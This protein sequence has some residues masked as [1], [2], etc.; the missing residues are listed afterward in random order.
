MPKWLRDSRTAL[1]ETGKALIAYDEWG[2]NPARAAGG[3][4]FNV[5]TTV[6]T[7]G[8][9]TAAK[10]GAVAR[11]VSALGKAGRAVDPMTYV[12]KA[13]GF[14]TVKVLDLFKTLK[15]LPAAPFTDGA[16]LTGPHIE[17]SDGSRLTYADGE[18]TVTHPDGT[19]APAPLELSAADR[20]LLDNHLPHQEPAMAGGQPGEHTAGHD[21]GPGAGSPSTSGDHMS[22]ERAENWGRG[23]T[24]SHGGADRA[25]PPTGPRSTPVHDSG[26][27]GRPADGREGVAH[28]DDHRSGSS[29]DE[30]RGH[31]PAEPSGDGSHPGHE[32]EADSVRADHPAEPLSEGPDYT[33]SALPPGQAHLSLDQLRR[34]RDKR[35]RW[36]A[37]EDYFRQMH[38]GGAERH[39][40]VPTNSH[41]LYPVETT[42]GRKVD[43]PV[44]LPD[45]RTLA[46]EVKTYQEYRTLTLDGGGHQTVK[47]E[48]P[49][50][51]H[52]REQI[53]KDLALRRA[54]PTFDPRWVFTHAGPSAE[55][56]KYLTEARI[57][58]VEYGPAPKMK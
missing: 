50:S 1:K 12:F 46:L 45:G 15:G 32:G 10:G 48:V 54:D 55:L 43:V 35:T 7:G 58:F 51:K 9:G 22:H 4:A 27:S 49:L 3:V 26:A 24:A 6:F 21:A 52:I 37:A 42:G 38:G 28:H 56:R 47:V 53:H 19:T 20:T 44:D 17:W 14:G 29:G 2:K 57:I 13:G 30:A 36:S 11:T 18:F 40:P 8:T 16:H 33:R 39:Y 25:E 41:P 5:L 23:P 34:L 31:G